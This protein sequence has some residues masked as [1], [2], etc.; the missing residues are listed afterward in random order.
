M[1]RKGRVMKAGQGSDAVA[2]ASVPCSLVDEAQWPPKQASS[3]IL[4]ALWKLLYFSNP[5][6]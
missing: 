6:N 1:V 3:L 2:L 4:W 5:E